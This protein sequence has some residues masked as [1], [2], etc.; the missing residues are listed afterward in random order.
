MSVKEAIELLDQAKVC[1]DSGYPNTAKG[2]IDLAVEQLKD[3]VTA[4][5]NCVL[6]VN[7]TFDDIEKDIKAAIKNALEEAKRDSDIE[8]SKWQPIR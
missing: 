6:T 8:A 2:F 4:K 7:V 1:V 5:E 3:V